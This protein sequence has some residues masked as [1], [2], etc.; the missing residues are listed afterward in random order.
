M[1]QGFSSKSG[2]G[3]EVI[4]SRY[5]SYYPYWTVASISL[6]CFGLLL[7]V[8]L[9]TNEPHRNSVVTDYLRQ[10]KILRVRNLPIK[11]VYEIYDYFIQKNDSNYIFYMTV[12]LIGQ[13]EQRII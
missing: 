8:K 6:S 4:T 10:V 3:E 12:A 9:I 2:W 7:Q 11:F 5:I 1:K 13:Q